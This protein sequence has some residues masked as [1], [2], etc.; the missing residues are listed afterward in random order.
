MK[1]IL[2]LGPTGTGKTSLA[3]RLCKEFEGLIVSVDSRQVYKHMDVGTGKIRDNNVRIQ[4]GNGWWKVNNLKIYGFDIITPDTT[5]SSFDFLK[6]VSSLN[7]VKFNKPVFFV[8]GTGFYFDCLLGNVRLSGVEKNT[9]LRL[10]LEKQNREELNAKLK[11]IDPI[12][13]GSIDSKNKVRL[14]RAIEISIGRNTSPKEVREQFSL[15]TY[16]IAQDPLL[17][18]LTGHRALLYQRADAWVDSIFD[19][20][21]MEEVTMLEQLG[22]GQSLPV[23]GLIY[24]SAISFVKGELSKKHAVERAKFDLHAYIRRQQTYF[25]KMKGINWLDISENGFDNKISTLVQSYLDG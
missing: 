18:G 21:L 3:L 7:L 10:D 2:L 24:K 9:K 19:T 16:L 1:A 8:G 4:K 6:Y 13:A 5:F 14:I 25:G 15:L 22:F 20:S 12:R 11:E 17:L 23:R